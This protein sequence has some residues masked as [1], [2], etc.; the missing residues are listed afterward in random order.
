MNI[1]SDVAILAALLLLVG[2]IVVRVPLFAALGA[3]GLLGLFLLGGV[4]GLEGASLALASQLQSFPLVAVPLFILMGA[5]IAATGMG[6]A[7]FDTAYKWLHRIPGGMS[8]ASVGASTIF[9]AMSGVSISGV[10]VIGRMAVPSML[11]KGYHPAFASGAVTAS[12]AL[13][14]LIPPSVM[15]ILYGELSGVDIAALF[16]GGIVPG[17]GLAA[18]M[19]LY[20]ISRAAL[21][22]SHAPRSAELFS[23][24]DRVRSL[25][26]LLPAMLLIV[27][28][29]GT[30]YGG[31]ATPTEAAAFGA[32][33][34]FLVAGMFYRALNGPTLTRILAETTR[35]S[36]SI[37]I[38]VA[39]A[40]V[41]GKFLVVA[42]VPDAVAAFL[43][44]LDLPAYLV[45]I[46][47]MLSLVLLGCLVDAA[48]LL[49]VVTPILVPLVMRLGFDPLW[50]GVVLVVNLEMAVI[51]PPVGLNLYAMKSA[52]PELELSTII[53]GVLPYIGLEMG[54][55]MLLITVPEI[56][57][58]LP[59]LIY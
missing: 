3:S 55:L 36:V 57:T 4:T 46:G 28:V 27:L 53:R 49:L 45:M 17:L 33:G 30:I 59:E 42:R 48:S 16:A 11:S 7:L 47:I 52:V 22:P 21:R 34:A 23:L 20:V 31:I 1:S 15:F 14:M 50:F 44:G 51:T 13:A 29:L 18:L 56:V 40:F 8:G 37:M 54:F 12:G 19:I 24:G 32:A 10:T 5:T 6:E 25:G 26:R 38:I 43:V 58:W 9:A 39:S 2:A 35:V 41:F